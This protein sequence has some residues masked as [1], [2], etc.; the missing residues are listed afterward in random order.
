[1]NKRINKK[2]LNKKWFTI[3][4]L[5]I[6]LSI[7]WVISTISFI[8]YIS[9]DSKSRDIRRKEDIWKIM[10]W[11]KNFKQNT[12]INPFPSN[13]FEIINSWSSNVYVYQWF[14]NDKIIINTIA[15]IPKDPKTWN[16]YLY[17]ITKNKQEFQVAMTLENDW[18]N[19][20]LVDW[21]YKVVAKNIFPS[22]LLALTS[23]G[24]QK[25]EIASWVI[26]AW[27]SWSINRLK[28]I[29]DWWYLNLPYNFTDWK[30][31]SNWIT[32]TFDSIINDPLVKIWTISSYF[33]CQEIY[34]AW[35]F[36]WNWI[37]EIKNID[38][39]YSST[40]CISSNIIG[41]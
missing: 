18:N 20:A 4:E 40:V 1:M 28:F 19:L 24:V 15:N 26:T 37:Y 33:S 23:S 36:V 29:L 8:N 10:I 38:W 5:I 27:S 7:L 25:V 9:Y 21:D 6:T 14:I 17:S 34:E 41:Y 30:P 31:V 16:D 39:N 35:K 12:N 3:I 22:L 32:K 13:Y 2:I 11:I